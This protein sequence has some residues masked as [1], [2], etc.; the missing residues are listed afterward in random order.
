MRDGHSCVN[1]IALLIHPIL[2]AGVGVGVVAGR[3]VV[4]VERD[5]IL[6]M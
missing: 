4:N 6:E 5:L 1:E 3:G 2:P